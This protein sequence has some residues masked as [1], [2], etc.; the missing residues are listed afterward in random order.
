MKNGFSLLELIFSIVVISIIGAFAVPKYMDTR[1]QA[2]ASTIQRDIVSATSSI[3]SYYLVKGEISA[4]GDAIN[5]NEK[6]WKIENKK[7]TFVDDENCAI[8]E[9]KD[10]ENKLSITISPDAGDVC[11]V[12]DENGVKTQDIELI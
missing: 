10:A 11:K 6:N 2:L 8:I 9:I 7:A 5:L 1:D 4:F 12:L 3:Q